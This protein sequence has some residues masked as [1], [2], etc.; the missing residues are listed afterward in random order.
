MHSWTQEAGRRRVPASSQLQLDATSPWVVDRLPQHGGG[1]TAFA[2]ALVALV[3]AAVATASAGGIPTAASTNDVAEGI[4]GFSVN[5]G[6]E[7]ERKEVGDRQ[8][9]LRSRGRWAIG[10]GAVTER[11][12]KKDERPRNEYPLIP[13]ESLEEKPH[14]MAFHSYE[15]YRH[16]HGSCT[17]YTWQC[18][19]T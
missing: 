11:M 1:A 6:G 13:C 2:L 15:I 19:I 7:W 12:W 3:L 16:I 17:V 5:N 10:R 14:L 4:G 8:R 18:R 9:G